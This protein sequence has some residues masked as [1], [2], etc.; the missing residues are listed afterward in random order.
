MKLNQELKLTNEDLELFRD[1]V[2]RVRIIVWD[3]I[4]NKVAI[5][6]FDKIDHHICHQTRRK[7]SNQ[8]NFQIQN[9]I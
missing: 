4:V 2:R 7:V 9:S 3:Q 5:D 6:I 1:R 8:I